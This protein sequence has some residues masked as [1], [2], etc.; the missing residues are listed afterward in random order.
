MGIKN[1]GVCEGDFIN[2]M[3]IRE[4][5]ILLQEISYFGMSFIGVNL[6]VIF[7]V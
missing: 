5:I 4:N 2:I 6:I 7:L 3:F 1:Q